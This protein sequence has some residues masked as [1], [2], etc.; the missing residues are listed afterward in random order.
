MPDNSRDWGD[1]FEDYDADYEGGNVDFP[2]DQYG[3]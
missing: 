1:E 2:L 3:E